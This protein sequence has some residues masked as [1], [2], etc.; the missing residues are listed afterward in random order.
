MESTQISQYLPC[1]RRWLINLASKS[2]NRVFRGEPAVLGMRHQ[3][4]LVFAGISL[5]MPSP[6]IVIAQLIVTG[7]PGGVGIFE[8]VAYLGLARHMPH[9]QTEATIGLMR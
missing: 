9:K 1:L 6:R 8:T 5:S 3:G 7:F 4:P 2:R